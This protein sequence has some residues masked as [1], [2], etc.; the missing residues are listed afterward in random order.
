MEDFE[1]QFDDSK[2]HE[3]ILGEQQIWKPGQWAN[4]TNKPPWYDGW[5]TM[6]S[7]NKEAADHL[8]DWLADRSQVRPMCG[9]DLTYPIMSLYRHYLELR[10]KGIQNDLGRWERLVDTRVGENGGKPER[11]FNHQLLSIWET[12]RR[13]L[14]KVDAD[15]LAVEGVCEEFDAIY[16]AIE[17]RI[18]EFNGIDERATSFRYPEEKNGEPTLGAPL[19]V[20]ELLQVK[21]VVDVLE[22]YLAGIRC[23]VSETVGETL[24]ALVFQGE[25]EAE[26]GW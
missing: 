18:K 6:A 13:L 24:E 1:A 5:A 12:V 19:G 7:A 10:L 25:L 26:Y 22:F 20:E 11:T 14:Y 17:E 4:G 16:D 23:G 21:S 15:E 2:L 9:T 3:S 8:V